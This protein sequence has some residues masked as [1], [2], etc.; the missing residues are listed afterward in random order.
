MENKVKIG[1]WAHRGC[2]LAYPENTLS[3]FRAAAEIKG[4]AGIELDIQLTKDKEIVV[5]HDETVD[6]TTNG[7]GNVEN[8]T[9]E[10]IKELEIAGKDGVTERIPTM[11]EVLQLL[12]KYCQENGLLINIELKNSKVRYEGME[13]MLLEL[14]QKYHL[15]DYVI[16]SSFLPESMRLM[17]ELDASVQTGILGSNEEWCREQMKLTNADAIHPWI[18]G[19]SL[20]PEWEESGEKYP[21]RVWN[22]E[23]PFFG[24]DRILREKNMLKYSRLGATD[25]ITNVPEMYL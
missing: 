14:V 22:T 5:I 16:Y 3:A 21:I 20:L 6:R 24:Q 18:G 19:L 25:V 8:F 17:K 23:E 9:L 13:E 1:V 4:I 2:S 15:K 11:E 10:E 12:Q 7:T